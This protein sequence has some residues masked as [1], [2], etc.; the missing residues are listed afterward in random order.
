MNQILKLFYTDFKTAIIKIRT[1]QIVLEQLINRNS[2]KE[3]EDIKKKQKLWNWEI[4]K[5]K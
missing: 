3:I 2:I 4:Q 1:L 5:P